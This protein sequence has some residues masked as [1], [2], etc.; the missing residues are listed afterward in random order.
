MD[1]SCQMDQ[2]S[3]VDIISLCWF[4][5]IEFHVMYL[6]TIINVYHLSYLYMVSSLFT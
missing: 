2:C 1:S 3:G 4:L 6:A 5:Y